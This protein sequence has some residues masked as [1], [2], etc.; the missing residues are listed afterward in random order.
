MK[1]GGAIVYPTETQ[2]GL[3]ALATDSDAV[4]KIFLIKQ[5]SAKKILPVIVCDLAQARRYFIFSKL[6]LHLAK[7]FWPGP[8][9]LILKT[10]SKK[11]KAALKS[12]E[13]AVRVSSNPLATSVARYA[14]APIVST[15]AN[16][17]GKPP[18]RTLREIKKQ[19]RDSPTQPDFYVS[20]LRS[21][22]SLPSTIIRTH[23]KKINIVREGK[24]SIQT[25][26]NFLARQ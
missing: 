23:G 1:R 12:D 4:K 11:I 21:A 10:K 5:R 22:S 13:I 19:F 25:V 17:S 18:R 6:D 26:K 20:G 14:D 9:S 2:Y 3:G 7:K 8:L 24:I 15:S 16:I